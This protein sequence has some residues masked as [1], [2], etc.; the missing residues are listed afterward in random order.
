MS[1]LGGSWAATLAEA[2]GGRSLHQR[3]RRR[4][5]GQGLVARR[6]GGDQCR[7]GDRQQRRDDSPRVVPARA[8]L[9]ARCPVADQ[10]RLLAIATSVCTIPDAG[11]Q[12]TAALRVGASADAPGL[13]HFG[14]GASLIPA[15]RLE[16]GRPD[17]TN[18][19]YEQNP[20]LAGARSVMSAAMLQRT[21]PILRGLCDHAS[22]QRCRYMPDNDQITGLICDTALRYNR[23]AGLNG[24]SCS[25]G[26][27]CAGSRAGLRV[28]WRR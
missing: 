13:A 15:A 27:S 7:Q 10:K 16:P 12:G 19:S 22:R 4:E 20:G 6:R 8:A 21:T 26:D 23:V 1:R 5:R 14:N 11:R 2:P 17:R 3:G 25:A 9:A 28:C 24:R 18:L